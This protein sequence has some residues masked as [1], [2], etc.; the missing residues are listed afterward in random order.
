MKVVVGIFLS[1]FAAKQI[2]QG[3]AGSA[4]RYE[5]LEVDL[6]LTGIGSGTSGSHAV[7][8]PSADVLEASKSLRRS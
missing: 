2:A 8:S 3:M 1:V 6:P 4:Y 5:W 7:C